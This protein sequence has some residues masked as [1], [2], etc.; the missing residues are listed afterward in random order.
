M[1]K[2]FYINKP[3]KIKGFTLIE[4][5]L[6]ISIGLLMSFISFQS[7]MKGQED[8]QAKVA[9]EQIKQLGDSVN[10]YIAVHYDKLASLTNAAGGTS[11]PGPR[12][13][14]TT[15]NTCTV[16]VKTLVNE[17]LLPTTYG[18]NNIFNSDY[19]ITLKRSG[20]SP[21]YNINGL[22][23][24][25]KPWIGAGNK[26]RYDL[27]GKAMQTAG[28]DSGM[29]NNSTSKVSGYNG[30]WSQDVS[31][32]SNIQKSG[33]LAYQVGYG[34]YSYS[35]Y[36]RRDGTL[37]MTGNLNMGSQSISNTKNITA[38]GTTQSGVLKSTGATT[39]GTTL[40][41]A[42]VTTLAGTNVNGALNANNTLTAAGATNLKS[43]LNI[44]GATTANGVVNANNALNV[45]GVTT[46]RN[47]ATIVGPLNANN[48]LNVAGVST[49]G[50]V[51]N[52]NNAV[53]IRG[54]TTLNGLL[55]VNN[56]ISSTGNITSSGQIQ[57]NNLVSNGR[58][59][60][61]E[62]V[63][64]NGVAKAGNACSPNGLQGR[65]SSGQLLSCANGKWTSI[66]GGFFKSPKPQ[67][68][69]CTAKGS[70][71]NW[72]YQARIDANGQIYNRKYSNNHDD[73]GWLIGANTF[74]S[75]NGVSG[76]ASAQS[77]SSHNTC[78]YSTPTCSASWNWNL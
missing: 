74:V 39:V 77:C 18:N 16:T 52:A 70:Y 36:L 50:G 14:N 69:Q 12:T 73:T 23:T 71:V 4:L 19:T 34:T 10:S 76:T 21:Y 30:N 5:I 60:M 48:A 51:L 2:N 3:N 24:T 57:A 9:G 47:A 33:Q 67:T 65:D 38:S 15:A 22:I 66:G 32:F 28:I 8:T 11:D 27:L 56:A 6:V 31:T 58:A 72:T 41:V 26:V 1:K 29:T 7:L 61:G 53:N 17:G 35:V 54:N 64:I 78:S 62:F 55:R 75:I 40:N 37:P 42:G 59:T 46:L 63:Q 68:I 49:L 43:T 13:C 45:A 20:N 44:A 25:N